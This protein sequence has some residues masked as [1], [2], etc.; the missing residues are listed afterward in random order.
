MDWL[1]AA[2]CFD[3]GGVLLGHLIHLQDGFVDLLDAGRIGLLAGWRRPSRR[4]CR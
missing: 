1:A 3:Q 4:R 2:V